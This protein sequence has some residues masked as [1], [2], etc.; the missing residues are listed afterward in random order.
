[1]AVAISRSGPA[2][3]RTSA[4]RGGSFR[5]NNASG[6]N[7]KRKK[8]KQQYRP[9]KETAIPSSP[10]HDE[11]KVQPGEKIKCP[12]C[13]RDGIVL[14]VFE[15]GMDVSHEVGKRTFISQVTGQSFEVDA[16]LDGCSMDGK[17][18]SNNHVVNKPPRPVLFEEPL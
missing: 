12:Y 7:M 2:T 10:T 17:I 18:G 6:A 16:F 8:K 5:A 1:M 9:Q 11:K 15:K 14:K 3:R 13:G 4:N